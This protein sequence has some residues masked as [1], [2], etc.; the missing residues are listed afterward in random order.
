MLWPITQ[1]TNTVG[2][3]RSSGAGPTDRAVSRLA[4]NGSVNVDRVF[5]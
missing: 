5:L 4:A 3:S 2:A 1:L